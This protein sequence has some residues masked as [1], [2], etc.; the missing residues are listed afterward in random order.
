ML[1]WIH[2]FLHRVC[3]QA[4]RD[5]EVAQ[6]D[7]ISIADFGNTGTLFSSEIVEAFRLVSEHDPRRFRR[8]R[9]ICRYVVNHVIPGNAPASYSAEW[10]ACIIDYTLMRKIEPVGFRGGCMA[11]LL[12]HESTHGAI[13]KRNIRYVGG[14]RL[15]IERLCMAEQNRFASRLFKSVPELYAGLHVE[16]RESDWTSRWSRPRSEVFL[17]YVHRLW[18]RDAA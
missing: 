5:H 12:V 15:R 14:A 1:N 13:E 4:V 18:S 6:F 11:C 16:F 2:T 10:A 3:I 9:Q 17:S 7:G 8:I